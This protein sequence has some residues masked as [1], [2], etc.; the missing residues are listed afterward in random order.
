MGPRATYLP[1]ITHSLRF[2]PPL[3]VTR[4]A[5]CRM[6]VRLEWELYSMPQFYQTLV[7]KQ[8]NAPLTGRASSHAV[9]VLRWG[10]PGGLGASYQ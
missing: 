3:R 6:T 1:L 4:M 5:I 10:P 2:A 9:G 8:T 7:N